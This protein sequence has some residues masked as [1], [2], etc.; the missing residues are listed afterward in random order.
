[1]KI[2][3]LKPRSILSIF[4]IL[5]RKQFSRIE[6]IYDNSKRYHGMITALKTIS[7]NDRVCAAFF[8]IF[9]T[10]ASRS[11]IF[12]WFAF[13]RR[14]VTGGETRMRLLPRGENERKRGTRRPRAWNSGVD[15]SPHRRVSPVS[16][17]RSFRGLRQHGPKL[18]TPFSPVRLVAVRFQK[19]SVSSPRPRPREGFVRF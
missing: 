3:V 10:S 14:A 13:I 15:R 7:P 11:S 12:D 1:M 9:R 17:A 5:L 8:L 6:K 19:R 16:L 4:S 2:D 18:A